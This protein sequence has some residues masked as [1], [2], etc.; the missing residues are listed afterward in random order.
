MELKCSCWLLRCPL[1][2]CILKFFPG[3]LFLLFELSDWMLILLC[4][5]VLCS[6]F[7]VFLGGVIGSEVVVLLILC[8]PQHMYRFH[9]WC[10]MFLLVYSTFSTSVVSSPPHV[11]NFA[12]LFPVIVIF[13]WVWFS[14]YGDG[15]LK[16]LWLYSNFKAFSQFWFFKFCKT[17][18]M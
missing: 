7:C 14:L 13:R 18:W 1:T 5:L 16:T 11:P 10:V 9:T 3:Y 2:P 6:W 12:V 15:K 4:I 17:L 8:Q